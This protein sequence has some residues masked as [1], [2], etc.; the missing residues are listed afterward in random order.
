MVSRMV[1]SLLLIAGMTGALAA[2]GHAG[3]IVVKLGLNSGKLTV[4]APAT[5]LKAG[6][7]GVLSLRVADSRG[8]GAGWT[9]K[10]AKG[11][12]VTVTKITARC[13]ARS[14]CTLPSTT[15]KPSGTT[16]LRAAKASGMGLIDLVVTVRATTATTVGFSIS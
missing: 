2:G 14:T 10:F 9:L 13:G 3:T 16:V 1:R 6:A 7:T 11:T 5:T 15:A 8:T 12:G 4:K